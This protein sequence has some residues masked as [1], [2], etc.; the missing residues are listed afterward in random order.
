MRR[1]AFQFYPGDWRANAKLRRCSWAARGAWVEIIC[2]LHDSEEY[3][4]LR[5][6]LEEIALA[7]GCPLECI[8]EL[9]LKGV[10]KGAPKG[11]FSDGLVYTPRTGRKFGD[12]V[13]L[14]PPQ[15]GCIWFSSRMVIDEYV[16]QRRATY[17]VTPINGDSSASPNPSPMPTFGAPMP[18]IGEGETPPLGAPPSSSSSSSLNN[19]SNLSAGFLEEKILVEILKLAPQLSG[20]KSDAIQEWL[21]FGADWELDILP[22]IK[23]VCEAPPKGGIYGFGIFTPLIHASKLGREK[24]SAPLAVELSCN[25]LVRQIHEKFIQRFGKENFVSWLSPM[26]EVE[27]SPSAVVLGTKN[28][29]SH[30]WVKNNYLDFLQNTAKSAGIGRLELKLVS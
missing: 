19:I 26:V 12:P 22:V 27:A 24:I 21:K 7:V 14:I 20:K 16:R 17:G 28:S 23:N 2:L 30:E 25:P 18:P 4:M 5:W 9:A 29:F 11:G 13:T 6:T 8:H 15:E 3:G 10:L 1:P